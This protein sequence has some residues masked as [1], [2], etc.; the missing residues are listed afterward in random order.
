M[1]LTRIVSRGIT[2]STITGDDINSTFNLTGKTVTLPAGVGGK[3]LQVVSTTKTDTFTCASTFTD[4]TGFSVSI[5]PSSA[6]NKILI[7][8]NIQCAGVNDG[9]LKLLRN[10]T[11]I[12]IGDASGS[13]TRITVGVR[14]EQYETGS[15]SFNFLDS[16]NTTSSITYKVQA[17]AT[18]TFY[19]NREIDDANDGFSNRTASTITAIEIAG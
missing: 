17:V 13:R 10:S 18:G 7:I 19:F 9:K 4:I 3:V 5:A 8:A 11:D 12:C 15:S 1:A 6:S 14:R 16:P 2:D